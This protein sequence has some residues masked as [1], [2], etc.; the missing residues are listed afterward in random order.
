ML[1]VAV[2]SLSGCSIRL[3]FRESLETAIPK[4][5][6]AADLGI[7]SAEADKTNDGF[8]INVQVSAVFDDADVTADELRTM[9]QL[10]VENTDLSKVTN[11]SLLALV[12]PIPD[13]ISADR[14]YIDLGA[15]GVELGFPDPDDTEFEA[16]W[17]DVVDFLNE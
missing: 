2:L 13:D 1:A 3:P 5:L 8:A 11:V 16:D 9:L 14:T 6:L 17:D 7:T 15:L 12:G 4:A 10:V